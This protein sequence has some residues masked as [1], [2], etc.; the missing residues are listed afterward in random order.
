MVNS[1]WYDYLY[2]GNKDSMME[3]YEKLK[4]NLVDCGADKNIVD[5][6]DGTTLVTVN[7]TNVNQ[8]N[9][10]LVDWPVSEHDGYNFSSAWYNTCLLYTSL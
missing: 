8:W 7:H 1:T 2:T 6:G 9:S 10:V 4:T 5:M 3:S